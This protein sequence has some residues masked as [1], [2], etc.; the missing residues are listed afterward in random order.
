MDGIA[1]TGVLNIL[2]HPFFLVVPLIFIILNLVTSSLSSKTRPHPPG[3]R[4]WPI[5]GNILQVGKKPH[6][7]LACFAK[8][9]GPLIS[10]RLGTQVLVVVSS[11]TAAAE[12]LRTHDR[13]LSA[14]SIPAAFPYGIHVLDRTAIVWNP[15]CSDRWKFLRAMCRTELFSAQAIKS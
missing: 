14:R 5:I 1:F 4:Q 3:P 7:L 13:L 6:V 2:S 11:P 9:H 10:L 12:I 15:T 8:V